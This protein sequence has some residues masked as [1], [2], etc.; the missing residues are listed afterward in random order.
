MDVLI[1]PHSSA[2][3]WQEGSASFFSCVASCEQK[4]SLPDLSWEDTVA[5]APGYLKTQFWVS[6]S[7]CL[8]IVIG[9]A[10]AL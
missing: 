8:P 9:L 3:G 6:I 4:K 10:V 7:P 1:S 5:D 2:Q